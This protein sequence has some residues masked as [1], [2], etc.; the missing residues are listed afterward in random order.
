[1]LNNYFKLV[2]RNMLKYKFFSAIN[3]LGMS[4]GITACLLIFLYVVH[5]LSYDQ[6]HPNA[7][8]LYQIVF[9]AR[10]GDQDITTSNTPPPLAGR[11]VAD[12]PG[13]EAATRIASFWGTPSLRVDETAFTEE[14]IFHADSNFFDFFGYKLIEGDPGTAL[15][16]P[17]TMVLTESLAKKYFG[18]ENAVSKLMTVGGN[19]TFKVTGVVADPP[20]NSHFRFKVLLSAA[21]S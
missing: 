13:V 14:K 11:F 3:I 17:N 5:E 8:R 21:S 2:V 1:M 7:D 4:I 9:H 19:E 18:S 12:I 6:F 15:L 16:E 10:I 20:E